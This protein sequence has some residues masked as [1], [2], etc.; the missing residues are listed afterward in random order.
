MVCYLALG[1]LHGPWS[2]TWPLVCYT[3][4]FGPPKKLG[5]LYCQP[6]V[7]VNRLIFLFVVGPGLYLSL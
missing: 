6:F 2:A 4:L 7:F 5:V 3:V 1:L